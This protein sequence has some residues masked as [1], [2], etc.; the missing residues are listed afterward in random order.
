[1]EDG[2]KDGRKVGRGGER[3][4]VI[5]FNAVSINHSN[6]NTHKRRTEGGGGGEAEQAAGGSKEGGKAPIWE[7]QRPFEAAARHSRW[8]KKC[9]F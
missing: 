9:H 8:T 5:N 7:E 6:T 4:N 3:G 1:M 2:R